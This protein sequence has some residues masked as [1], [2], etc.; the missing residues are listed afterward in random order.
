MSWPPAKRQVA[1]PALTTKSAGLTEGMARFRAFKTPFALTHRVQ[2]NKHSNHWQGI[3][4]FN[5]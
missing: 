5:P 4:R 3:A 2:H 1:Q